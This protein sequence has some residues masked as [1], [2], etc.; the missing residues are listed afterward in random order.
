MLQRYMNV[1]ALNGLKI[2]QQK[3]NTVQNGPLILIIDDELSIIDFI[4]LGMA[5]EGFRVDSARDGPSGLSKA[6]VLLPDIIILDLMLP[7]LSGMDVCRQLRDKPETAILPIIML[8]AKDEVRH[9]IAGL[10]IGADDYMTK[11]FSFDELLAR[12]H[13]VLRRQN[14]TQQS[15]KQ[16]ILQY[17]D[18]TLDDISREVRRGGR[19][20]QLTVTEYN[21]LKLFLLHPK[22]VLDRMV[23]LERVWGYDFMG[24]SNI[25]EVYVRYLRE[26]L[27]EN[28]AS[29]SLIHT[30]RGVGY[31]LR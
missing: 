24:D 5:Q 7:G 26:K 19:L 16:Q 29:P 1:N 8:T 17:A 28:P 6:R 27:E 21:L 23:I 15:E 9:K 14:R 10:E 18:I 20:I 25:I 3:K 31:V 22:Q 11:P 4:S 12:V 13:A 30:V 2:M